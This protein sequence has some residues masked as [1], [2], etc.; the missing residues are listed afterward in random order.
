M[1]TRSARWY[2]RSE[3][4]SKGRPNL[5]SLA[6][7][8]TRVT[9]RNLPRRFGL[10]ALAGLLAVFALLSVAPAPRASAAGASLSHP[11][12]NCPGAGNATV[13]FQWQQ[14]TG[15]TAQYL[16]LSVQDGSFAKDTFAGTP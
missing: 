8:K 13:A 12:V 3:S 14:I 4:V 9:G 6:K 11:S 16:D 7:E 5:N 2:T 10:T 1:N 15:G